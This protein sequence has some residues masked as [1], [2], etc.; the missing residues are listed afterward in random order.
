VR[1][2]GK[3]AGVAFSLLCFATVAVIAG[4]GEALFP[5]DTFWQWPVRGLPAYLLAVAWLA[6]GVGVLFASGIGATS[7]NAARI[8]QVRDWAFVMMGVAFVASG[9]IE[10]LR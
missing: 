4:S 10:A 8:R 3:I 5:M 1:A 7:T 2:L 6:L 9:I